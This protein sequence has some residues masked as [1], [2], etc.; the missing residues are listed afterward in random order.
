MPGENVSLSIDVSNSTTKDV[1]RIEV[2]LIER[3]TYTARRHNR[4]L[5][6]TFGI[7]H[8]EIQKK[9]EHR[10]V[11]QYNEE[12]KVASNSQATYNR[13]LAIPPVVPSFN[14]CAIIQVDYQFKVSLNF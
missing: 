14:V 4:L 1:S 11:V 10:N 12:F 13:L 6:N 8:P 3:V 5:D 9:H 2:A 7:N